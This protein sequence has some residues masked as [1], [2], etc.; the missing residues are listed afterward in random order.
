MAYLLTWSSRATEDLEEIATYIAQDSEFYASAVVREILEKTRALAE[1]PL[2]GRI[3][4]EFDDERIREVFAYSYRI[5]YKVSGE[6]I[7]IAAIVHGRR[8]IEM[9]LTS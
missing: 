1:F 7:E 3:V 9:A 2:L 4:P 5:I 6:S 8:R